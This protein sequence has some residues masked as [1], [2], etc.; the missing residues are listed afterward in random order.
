VT[1]T[2]DGA[3]IGR[4]TTSGGRFQLYDLPHGSLTLS[5]RSISGTTATA[6]VSYSG[7]AVTVTLSTP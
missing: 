4:A 1:A 3:A 2:K 5:F 7:S 6:T